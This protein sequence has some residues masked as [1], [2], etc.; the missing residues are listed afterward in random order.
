MWTWLS[1]YNYDFALATI[2]IQVIL[3]IVYIMRQQLPTRQSRSFMLV[4]VMNIIMTVTDIIACELNEVWQEYPISLSYALNIAYFLA[5]I[6]RGWGLF[7]Y[8]ASVV[9]AASRWGRKFTLILAL[10][11]LFVCGLILS[12]PWAGTIFTMDPVTGY[13]NLGWYNSI[14]FST[15]FYII[16]SVLLMLVCRKDVVFK[17]KTGIYICNVILAVG[18]IYRHAFMHLSYHT[19]SGLLPGQSGRRAEQSR[20]YRNGDGFCTA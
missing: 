15:W 11:A 10:P 16:A 6:I 9:D 19:E 3:M 4:M 17:A 18:L 1:D 12:T 7:D 13:H 5:F 20:F 2:P 14:Y 8:A